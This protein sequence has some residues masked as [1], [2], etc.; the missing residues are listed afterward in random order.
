TGGIT[1]GTLG[2]WNAAASGRFDSRR[3]VVETAEVTGSAAR[4]AADGV[5]GVDGVSPTELRLRVAALD[6]RALA[7]AA[8]DADLPVRAL[9]EG[10]LRYTTKGLD[11]AGGRAS[12]SL[13]LRPAPAPGSRR[14]V[15]PGVPLAGSA[16]LAVEGR[17]VHLRRLRLEARDTRLAGEL[18]LSPELDV[19]GRFEA[20]VPLAAAGA[21]AADV[22]AEARPELAGTIEARGTIAGPVK[23]P[24]V[25]FALRGEGLAP[26]GTVAAGTVSVEGAGRYAGG[27]VALEPLVLRS[28]GGQAVVRG[29]L[30]LD[31]A[32]GAWDLEGEARALELGPLLAAAGVEA[33]GPL[34]GRLRVDG[35]YGKPAARGDLDA[36]LSLAGVTEPLRVTASG[37]FAEGRIDV[38]RLVAE[39]AGGRVEAHGTYDTATR[40]TKASGSASGLRLGHAP[41]WPAALRG[42]DGRV[43]GAFDVAGTLDAPVGTARVSIEETTLDGRPLPGVRLGATADGARLELEGATRT[44]AGGDPR[45]ATFLRGRGALR[46]D[47]PL[48]LELDVS[49]LPAQALFDALPAAAGASIRADGRVV[50]EVSARDPRRVRYTGE[51]LALSGRL[52]ELEW[53][54]EPFR[55]QGGSEEAT[56]SG[57]RLS[58]RT[59]AG[60]APRRDDTASSGGPPAAGPAGGTLSVDGR[61]PFA[62]DRAF[63]LAV[64]GGLDLAALQAIA[65]EDRAAG[66]AT[67]RARVR[68]TLEAPDVR[69]SFGLTGARGRFG[70]TRVSQAELR[71]RFE[72][73]EAFLDEASARVLGGAVRATGS[74]PFAALGAGRAAR[75]RFEATDVDLSRLAIPFAERTPETPS[76]LVSASGEISATAPRLD[77]VRAE[78]RFTRVESISPEGRVGLVAAAAWRFADGRFVQEPIRLAGPLGTVEARAEARLGGKDPGGSAVVAGPFDL[79]V[80]SPFVP[81]TSL[82]GP[83]RVDLRAAWGA[84]G[85]TVDGAITVAGGRVTL[86]T[87][88]FTATKLE[89]E[90]RF[91]GDHATLHATAASGDGQLSADGRMSFG[92]GLLGPAELALDARRVPISY[93]EGFR[94]RAT[95]VLHVA[96]DA[97]RYEVTGDVAVSQAYYTAD[98]DARGQS[99]DRLDYQLAAIDGETSLTERLPLRIAVRLADPVRVR[100]SQ[101]SL[102]IVGTFAVGGTLAQPVA[103]G[104]LS[105]L[106]GGRLT[107]RRARVRPQDGRVELNGYPTGVPEVDFNGV[108]QVGGVAMTL[109][110]QGSMEDLQLDIA[111]SN[112]PDLSQSDLLSLL[113]TGRTA[114]AAASQ[115][116]A[117]V[118]EELASALG[119]ALQKGV[120]ET[121][122]IDVSSDQTLQLDESDPTERFNVGTRLRQDLA[123]VYSTRLDGTEQRFVVEWNPRGGRFRVRGIDDRASGL[124]AEVTDRLSFDLVPRRRPATASKPAEPHKL[125]ALRLEG[126]PPPLAEKELV[127][128]AGLTVGH[129]YDPPRIEQAADAV[130]AKLVQH[131][132][133]GAAVDA[134]SEPVKG[135]ERSRFALVLR[136]VPGPHVAVAWRGDDP[137]ERLRREAMEAWPA[138]ASPEA[139]ASAVARALRVSLQARGFYEARVEA[140]T[141]TEAD[142]AEVTFEVTRGRKGSRVAVAFEGNSALTDARL[143]ATLPK[144]G[145]RA[146]FEALDRSARLTAEARIAYAS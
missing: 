4:L 116:A 96:G 78:G 36:R 110:A 139:A 118:A 146:F 34:N 130:R 74:L 95:G 137:G 80:I 7:R 22:G 58:T 2:R 11:P 45:E 12:G 144:P 124:A 117:I 83:A 56:I 89:G 62:A 88:Q 29:G 38:E 112:R 20:T 27:R 69:G 138:Y 57:L 98:F 91:A 37:S 23:A 53:S 66:T 129:R 30:P 42:L 46:G 134:V 111:S 109:R 86:E 143:A 77:A 108:T 132:F 31:A 121:F 90:V 99:L 71:G 3:L 70:G 107:I 142:Q 85:T 55:V 35:P 84:D 81:D 19:D 101:A 32:S 68:G 13:T 24:T 106:E 119:G 17:R 67:L 103:T 48:R 123:V 102:D 127:D 135:H 50:V 65:P 49:A 14:G 28:G 33:R 131:G 79:R 10:S 126:G 61:V 113:L 41:G 122:L 120:G 59:T 87:L 8:G 140:R 100:N 6:V 125:T 21:L 104:Q 44:D 128:A 141:R 72:G 16:D 26:V 76:F 51:G 1:V 9:L 5:V 43:G 82:A 114:Q 73:A 92:P 40:A 93:P 39:V 63:D 105:L 54:T 25:A 18:S 15:P 47:W 75:L 60:A 145:S 64:E 94:G 115:S 136:V 52:R 133:R 97:G